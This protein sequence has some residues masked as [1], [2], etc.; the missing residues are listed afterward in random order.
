MSDKRINILKPITDLLSGNFFG[1]EFV[2][3]NMGFVVYLTFLVMLYIGYGYYADKQMKRVA[4][5][6]NMEE[7][8]SKDNSATKELNQ[9]SLQSN[10]LK[11]TEGK[12]IVELKQAPIIIKET[13][14][15]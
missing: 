11:L 12:G 6:E 8:N 5:L 7:L 15:N 1:K 13:E 4:E 14:V 9:I 3:K 2:Q 10:V